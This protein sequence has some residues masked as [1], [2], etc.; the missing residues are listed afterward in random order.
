[1]GACVFIQ[2][3]TVLQNDLPVAVLDNYSQIHSILQVS[4]ATAVSAGV[5][6]AIDGSSWGMNGVRNT[7][8]EIDSEI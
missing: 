2:K 1:M 8:K 7:L 5:R 3:I 6:S 4:Q